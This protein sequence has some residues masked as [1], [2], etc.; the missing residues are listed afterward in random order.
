MVFFHA[1]L[2]LTTILSSFMSVPMK[3]HPTFDYSW[4]DYLLYGFFGRLLPILRAV[5]FASSVTCQQFYRN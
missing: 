4:V 5:L 3:S 2:P 1:H